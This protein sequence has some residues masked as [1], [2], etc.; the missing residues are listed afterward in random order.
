MMLKLDVLLVVV[1]I[2]FH[3]LMIARSHFL[4]S[5]YGG[6]VVEKRREEKIGRRVYE[7]MREG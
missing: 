3:A 2:F 5:C 1:T 7:L 6:I 4:C